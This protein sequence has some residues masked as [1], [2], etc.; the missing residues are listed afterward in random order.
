MPYYTMST[1]L[2]S[3]HALFITTLG[4]I[5]CRPFQERRLHFLTLPVLVFGRLNQSLT[6]FV[7]S[8]GV[9]WDEMARL[10]REGKSRMRAFDDR[11]IC[12]RKRP[13]FTNTHTH[14]HTSALLYYLSRRS[15]SG[16]QD[17]EQWKLM[18]YIFMNI[19][20]CSW[21]FPDSVLK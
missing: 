15:W 14:T 19:G 1:N 16:E 13:I 3:S 21:L 17:K 20:L 4:Q 5:K 2:P 7:S 11:V 9:T 6:S 12:L 10:S 18:S 8:A